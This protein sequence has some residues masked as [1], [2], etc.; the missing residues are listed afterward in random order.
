METCSVCG[1]DD[2]TVAVVVVGT[3]K[4]SQSIEPRCSEHR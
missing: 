2:D 4:G 1:R 3:T